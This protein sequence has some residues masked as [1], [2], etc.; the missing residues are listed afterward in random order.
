MLQQLRRDL[1]HRPEGRA[2]VPN[3]RSVEVPRRVEDQTSV[4]ESSWTTEEPVQ[5]GLCP[6]PVRVRS[7]LEDHTHASAAKRR[8]AVDVPCRIKDQASNR[9]ISVPVIKTVQHAFRP[10]SVL[11]PRQFKHHATV[12]GAPAHLCSAVQ[13]PRLVKDQA[14]LWVSGVLA[15]LEPLEPVEHALRPGSVRVRHQFEDHATLA[16]GAVTPASALDRRAVKI[17]GWVHD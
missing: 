1:K 16:S 5:H 13:I 8:G 3:G 12:S 10:A 6:F 15:A 14:G 11:L 17:S 2:D 9:L 4:G 7:Q